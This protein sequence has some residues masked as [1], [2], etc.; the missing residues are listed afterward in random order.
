VTGPVSEPRPLEESVRTVGLAEILATLRRH[1][2]LILGT[3]A[4]AVAAA[5]V[6]THVTG[7]VYRAVAV[8]RLSDPRRALTGGVVDDPARADE[9][10]ADPLLSQVELLTSRAVAGAV[11]DSVPMLRLATRKFPP[12]LLGD[13][14]VPA[15]AEADTFQLTFGLD[16]F[17]VR[18]P[19]LR[20]AAYGATVEI[21]GIRLTVRERPEVGAGELHVL[22]RA[23]AVSRLLD[24][25]R[26]KPRLRTDLV[27]VAYSAPDPH[28]AQQVVNRVVGIFWTTSAEAAQQQSRR[29]REFLEAQLVVNDSLLADAREAQTEFRRRA[30]AY[31]S[32]EAMAR[33]EVGLAGIEL[34]RQ[35]LEAERS[36]YAQLLVALRDTTGSRKALQTAFS[37]PGVATSPEVAQI[38]AQLFEYEARRDSLTS[39]SS[40][41][42]DLPRLNLLIAS[43]ETKARRAVQ[44]AVQSAVVSFDGRIA[45]MNEMRARQQRLS[46]TEGEE[47]RLNERVE[48]ARKVVDALRI[49]TQHAR[50]AEAVTVGHVEI[51]DHASLPTEPAGIGVAE[52]LALGLLMGLMLGAAGAFLADRLGHAIAGRVQVEQL[53]VS[54]LGV[55]PRAANEAKGPD[56]IIEAFR[57]IRLGLV[58]ACG[59]GE[60]IV[61]AV[62]SPASGDG[63]SFVSSNLALA[64]ARARHRT[65][66]IDADLRRGALH[67]SVALA[68]RP[69]LTDYLVEDA[70][71]EQVVQAT[72]HTGL[73]LLAS[74]SRRRDAPELLSAPRM[75]DLLTR[76]RSTYDVV[77]LDTPP[78]AAGVDALAV[79]TAAGSVMIVL[80]LG[81]THRALA[82][83]KLDV[84]RR[85]PL[86]LLGAILND[87]REGSEYHAY[88]YY[89]DGYDLTTESPY[90]PH[91]DDPRRA[92][93]AARHPVR[94][95]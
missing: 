70:T 47:D 19:S 38:S 76:L 10:F 94:R 16:S 72:H 79:G 25:L 75:V 5:G 80:R 29:R 83:A 41:H 48:N 53:G 78:L 69:G 54:I 77:V 89:M 33:Q 40:T 58:N 21:A 3:V 85:V 61:V 35:Q 36:T 84:L 64:F 1:V 71:P 24:H 86:R 55:V 22:T 8:I 68:R 65:L 82:E 63:K 2:R 60:P 56:P 62:T 73:D 17:T 31:G 46:A 90:R 93:G 7:P 87:V 15:A 28:V 9:R 26:V 20:R 30:R 67:R 37:I 95:S 88:S 43:T 6:V 81:T 51:V 52:Q 23:A 34:Q 4:V 11:V 45:A 57:G 14:A 42:P 27:D 66:L 39:R 92:A 12:G 32:R 91:E 13:V 74:G 59:A 44:A 50:I 18:G 49:E